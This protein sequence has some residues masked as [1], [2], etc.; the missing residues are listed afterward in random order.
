MITC[1]QCGDATSVDP[2]DDCFIISEAR[3]CVHERANV[4]DRSTDLG[5]N[6]TRVDCLD[7]GAVLEVESSDGAR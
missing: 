6:L 5:V 3:L 7:C 4:S 2:C 1:S